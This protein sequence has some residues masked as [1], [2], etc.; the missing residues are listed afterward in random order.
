MS[1]FATSFSS[2]WT[3]EDVQKVKYC[4]YMTCSHVTSIGYDMRHCM[5]CNWVPCKAG[6]KLV[7]EW[8]LL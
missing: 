1:P 6:F 2:V 8:P 7:V 4:I 3:R 5:Y